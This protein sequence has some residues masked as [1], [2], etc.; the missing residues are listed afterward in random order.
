MRVGIAIS[1]TLVRK[2]RA[3]VLSLLLTAGYPLFAAESRSIEVRIT[4]FTAPKS[5]LALKFDGQSLT[6]TEHGKEPR[7]VEISK[8]TRDELAHSL[9]HFRVDDWTGVWLT[10][11]IL[12]GM[13]VIG[14][15]ETE[16]DETMTFQGV[17]GCPPGFARFL[18]SLDE[19]IGRADLGAQWK[20]LEATSEHHESLEAATNEAVRK[21]E[22]TKD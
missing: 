21:N 18:E 1:L 5:G 10:P 15:L 11:G 4:W 7:T 2:M 13:F 6:L 9:G 12:D 3:I 17:N 16:E 8:A 19:A 22:K 20:E 14:K